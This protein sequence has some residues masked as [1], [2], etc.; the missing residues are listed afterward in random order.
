M[1][2]LDVMERAASIAK[3]FQRYV[4][5]R[6]VFVGGSLAAGN[7][8]EYSDLDI[9][10]VVRKSDYRR[11]L[12]RAHSVLRSSGELVFLKRLDH[13]FAMDVFVYE[14]GI[15]GELGIARTA[16]LASL[17]YGPYLVMFDRDGL[18]NGYVFPGWAPKTEADKQAAI[19][20]CLLW[21]WRGALLAGGYLARGD[22][23]S[24]AHQINEMRS[25]VADLLRLEAGM[26]PEGGLSKLGRE[27]PSDKLTVLKES[28][29]RL[30]A[31]SMAEVLRRLCSFAMEHAAQELRSPDMASWVA[32]MSSLVQHV[33]SNGP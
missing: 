18:L 8:D 28:F 12:A 20:D 23:W 26:W 24:L 15:R 27:L 13:G 31:Q 5:V 29:V 2:R 14:D 3:G 22:L 16:D 9:Y 32:R 30:D 6:A 19:A 7:A 4:G 33:L 10:V 11:I 25:R 17:H 1:E 21:F